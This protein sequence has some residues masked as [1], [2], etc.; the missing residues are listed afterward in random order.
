MERYIGLN[1][2]ATAISQVCIDIAFVTKSLEHAMFTLD[3][4]VYLLSVIIA[5][6]CEYINA[7]SL[8]RAIETQCFKDGI[9]KSIPP[10]EGIFISPTGNMNKMMRKV[11]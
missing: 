7:M 11:V 4:L 9:N 6:F 1:A 10:H 3:F 2:I 8:P 5:L